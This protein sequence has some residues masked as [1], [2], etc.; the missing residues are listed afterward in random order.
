MVTRSGQD[1]SK[2]CFVVL[3][4]AGHLLPV[5]LWE[6]RPPAESLLSTLSYRRHNPHRKLNK[7]NKKKKSSQQNKTKSSDNNNNKNRQTNKHAKKTG[8]GWIELHQ[9]GFC[10]FDWK[11]TT[12]HW[13]HYWEMP[14]D[15]R[16][17]VQGPVLMNGSYFFQQSY[18]SALQITSSALPH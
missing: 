17:N 8:Q 3:C 14:M 2:A 9:R 6:Q 10:S 16:Y 15:S 18:N 13:C 11:E 7:E 5:C 12:P 1:I 4:W